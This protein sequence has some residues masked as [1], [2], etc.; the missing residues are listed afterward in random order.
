MLTK[1]LQRVCSCFIVLLSTLE[2]SI[3]LLRKKVSNQVQ[4]VTV[5][6]NTVL[7]GSSDKAFDKEPF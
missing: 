1:E 6:K 3:V 7:A 2:F 4:E 5:F